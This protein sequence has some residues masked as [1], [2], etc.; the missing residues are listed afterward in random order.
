MNRVPPPPRMRPQERAEAFFMITSGM[1]AVTRTIRNEEASVSGYSGSG[2]SEGI[3]DITPRTA[4]GDDFMGAFAGFAAQQSLSAPSTPE[5]YGDGQPPDVTAITAN[6]AANTHG[7]AGE[8]AG[9][10]SSNTKGVEVGTR[11]GDDCVPHRATA[12]ITERGD[13]NPHGVNA[14]SMRDDQRQVTAD[15]SEGAVSNPYGVLDEASVGDAFNT[16]GM[17][18]ETREH[19]PSYTLGETVEGSGGASGGS[20][21]SDPRNASER[22]APML[23]T[24]APGSGVPQR[25][26]VCDDT[27]ADEGVLFPNKVDA[28]AHYQ[29]LKGPEPATDDESRL[30][31]ERNYQSPN[32]VREL[33]LTRL[34]EGTF[35]GEMALI[36][37]EP[38]N[39]NVRAA[40]KVRP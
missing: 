4:D 14:G 30:F 39:A 28:D 19:V 15:I 26:S 13:S 22:A 38:R 40:T 31:P 2:S 27:A 8:I 37:D 35:F 1:V 20:R 32:Y 10:D 9:A 34:Y 7:V 18:S 3:P 6:D 36:Y 11:E 25:R 16:R 23:G 12:E 33:P 5:T 21:S 24:T 29:E 17:A